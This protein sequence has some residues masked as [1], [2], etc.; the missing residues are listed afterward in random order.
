MIFDICNKSYYFE[1]EKLYKADKIEL[2]ENNV[3]IFTGC[4]GIGKSTLIFQITEDRPTA[5]K[6]FAYNLLNDYNGYNSF[7]NHFT[8]DKPNS[9]SD[10]YYLSIDK[11]SNARGINPSPFAKISSQ[12]KSSGEQLIYNMLPCLEIVDKELERLKNKTLY[13]LLDDLDVGTSL[14]VILEEKLVI[15]RFIK[16]LEKNNTKYI[17]CISANNYELTKLGT[18]I[19]CVTLK[20]IEFKDYDDYVNYVVSTRK[21]KDIRNKEDKKWNGGNI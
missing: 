11:K 4:N 1:N 19:D 14:D 5:L 9:D 17:I 20:P 6:H 3:Y 13:L 8:D 18:C 16:T 21:Y 7:V 2:L 15:K 12:F 10:V